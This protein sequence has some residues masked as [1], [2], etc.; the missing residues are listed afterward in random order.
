MSCTHSLHHSVS[1]RM[2]ELQSP[3]TQTKPRSVIVITSQ[4]PIYQC[5]FTSKYSQ[6]LPDRAGLLK[7]EHLSPIWIRTN[8]FTTSH[9]STAQAPSKVYSSSA[10]HGT[11]RS[12]THTT[13]DICSDKHTHSSIFP[14]PTVQIEFHMRSHAQLWPVFDHR[15]LFTFPTPLASTPSV[16]SHLGSC[17]REGG[18][19][20]SHVV[21]LTCT[22]PG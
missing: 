9:L 11:P 1:L 3:S 14:V 4:F 15:K 16:A 8:I 12:L 17:S 19:R 22:M 5:E 20:A 2:Y 7:I 6:L 10:P 18:P 13:H 21:S